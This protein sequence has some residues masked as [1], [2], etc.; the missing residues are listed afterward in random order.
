MGAQGPESKRPKMG[1]FVFWAS[2]FNGCPRGSAHTTI[3]GK[4]DLNYLLWHVVVG[5][6]RFLIVVCMFFLIWYIGICRVSGLGLSVS[7][8][9][10]SVEHQPEKHFNLYQPTKGPYYSRVLIL[11]GV[12]KILSSVI[13]YT[14]L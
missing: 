1:G 6:A 10:S 9:H 5:G 13:A 12:A 3:L 8:Y 4:Q 14:P 2:T 11:S 7:A